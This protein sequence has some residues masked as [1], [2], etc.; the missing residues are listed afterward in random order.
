[1]Q[2]TSY[3]DCYLYSVFDWEDVDDSY[4]DASSPALCNNVYIKVINDVNPLIH[5]WFNKGC[6]LRNPLINNAFKTTFNIGCVSKLK[7]SILIGPNGLNFKSNIF[8]VSQLDLIYFIYLLR[9]IK[10][11][12]EYDGSMS[13]Q[14]LIVYA[15]NFY[16]IKE[17]E[18]LGIYE[19]NARESKDT[20]I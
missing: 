15:R 3:K 2:N 19:A 4:F 10:E 8:F 20:S 12:P 14:E 5:I 18:E 1:M 17:I 9:V 11:Q 16:P 7:K 6:T 13:K